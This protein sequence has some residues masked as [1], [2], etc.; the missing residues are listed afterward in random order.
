MEKSKT[1][2]EALLGH[3][4]WQA[5]RH[6]I[7]AILLDFGLEETVKWGKPCYLF[8]GKPVAMIFNQKAFCALGFPKGALLE[9][10]MGAL[11]APGANSQSMRRLQFTSR[12]QVAK[13]EALI[14]YFLRQVIDIERDGRDV[15]KTAKDE[16]TLPS[17]LL[18]VL[19]ADPQYAAAFD[20][21]TPGR[22]RSYI[23]HFDAA[24]KPQTRADRIA[25]SRGKVLESKGQ[26][27]R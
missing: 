22:K 12:S 23:I 7:R 6:A 16:L 1:T 19:A 17:D 8:E 27:E 2:V 13:S 21:L 14:R 18:D 9:D 5:E 24:K 25:K 3:A 26:L 20:R 11:I 10:H 4:G 15:E